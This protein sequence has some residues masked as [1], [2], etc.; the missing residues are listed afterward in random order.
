M[1]GEQRWKLLGVEAERWGVD[2]KHPPKAQVLKAAAA[3][4]RG[5]VPGS[6]WMGGP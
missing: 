4:I 3:A 2:I 1:E 5:G 6:D